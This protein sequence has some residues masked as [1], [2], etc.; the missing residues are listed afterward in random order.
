MGDTKSNQNRDFFEELG[1]KVLIHTEK[2]TNKAYI[3]YDIENNIYHHNLSSFMVFNIVRNQKPIEIFKLMSDSK[4]PVHLKEDS[5]DFLHYVKRVLI[6]NKTFQNE[7]YNQIN[8]NNIFIN[9][10]DFKPIA[11]NIYHQGGITYLNLY[12]FNK[13][14]LGL[15][16][17]L[18]APFPNI[19]LFLRN[20]WGDNKE[21]YNKFLDVCAFKIQYPLEPLTQC[22]FIIQDD[23]GTGKSSVFYKKILDKL[24]NVNSITQV[25]LEDK[26]NSFMCNCQWV[27]VEEVESFKDAK[28]IKSLTG[29]SKIRMNE[30]YEKAVMINNYSSMIIC[31]NEVNPLHI[32]ERDRRFN[33]GGGG[34]RLEPLPNMSWSETLFKSEERYNK[35]YEDFNNNLNHEIKNLYSHLL[36]RE[37]DVKTIQRLVSTKQRDEL[38]NLGKTTEKLFIDDIIK[39]G[40]YEVLKL[41][42]KN[43]NKLIVDLI[44][45]FSEGQYKGYWI[46]FSDFYDIYL[47]Y[48]RYYLKNPKL[49]IGT[50]SFYSRVI[51]YKPSKQIIGNKTR[52]RVDDEPQLCIE[53]KSYKDENKQPIDIKIDDISKSF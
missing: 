5:D 4:L 24:F 53:L 35:F 25:D 48:H 16:P 33:V 11:K 18:N 37:V 28:R 46:K 21:M 31:S 3:L 49:P 26:Y 50:K 41:C 36:A 12:S 2:P 22:N 20:I 51:T 47:D 30:K 1:Y 6:E 38:I 32:D 39:H 42:K 23:G 14:F 40:I 9:R 13:E 10:I 19:E 8:I 52:I 27:F 17:N 34:L 29:A 44:H 7:F 45:Y 43:Y 15:K